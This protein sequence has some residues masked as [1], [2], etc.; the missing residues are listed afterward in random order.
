MF[1]NPPSKIAMRLKCFFWL[2]IVLD[3]FKLNVLAIKIFGWKFE[4]YHVESFD[5]LILNGFQNCKFLEI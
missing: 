2:C 1:G 3:D 4:N 5:F